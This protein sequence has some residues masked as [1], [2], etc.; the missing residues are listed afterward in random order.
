MAA[1]EQESQHKGVR[2]LPFK[3]VDHRVYFFDN[4]GELQKDGVL[5]DVVIEVEGRRFP[6]H[7][8]VLSVRCPYFRAMFSSDMAESRQKTVVLQDMDA[9]VFEEI[10]SYF[11]SG[12][13]YVSLDK[14]KSLYQ[15]AD[16]LQLDYVK[17]AC[18][19]YMVTN[20]DSSNC[21]DLY[22]FADFFSM[23]TVAYL[24]SMDAIRNRSLHFICR[25]FSEVSHTKEFYSLSVNQL[26]R[27]ISHDKLDVKQEK[28]VWE[29]VV[30]WVQHSRED[31]LQHLPSILPHIRFNLLTSDD[32][33]AILQHPMVRENSGS[34]EVSN[35]AMMPKTSNPKRR[36]GMDAQEM[37]LLFRTIGTDTTQMLCYN[38]RSKMYIKHSYGMEYL[39]MRMEVC[40]RFKVLT[41]TVTCNNDIYTLVKESSEELGLF[42]YIHLA[43]WWEKKSSFHREKPEHSPCQHIRLRAAQSKP[44]SKPVQY[45]LEVD[46][47]L[48]Y[49]AVHVT[50]Q[51]REK[52]ILLVMKKYQYSTDQWQ[53]CSKPSA[54]KQSCNVAV[55][56]GK[57]LYLI[58]NTEMHRYDPSQDSWCKVT[59]PSTNLEPC[60]AV[61]MG[62]EIFCTDAAVR[63]ISVYDVEA[64]SWSE[65]PGWSG[66]NLK[67][68]LFVLEG[69]L[70]VCLHNEQIYVYDR[71][72]G[73]W[74]Y[75]LTLPDGP[76]GICG[77]TLPV[78]R[79]Y[80]YNPTS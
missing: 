55:S 46:G 54:D 18:K 77:S 53:D 20:V 45:L 12:T 26:T 1:A 43:N 75:L 78:A 74:K 58:T 52:R 36:I 21:V 70:H 11:Y 60:T 5:Q 10:L 28:T 15:A 59:P 34:S 17:I 57:H 30:R 51:S 3:D 22:R 31:R 14:V 80:V 7:R 67:P 72:E 62:T 73:A 25:F 24:F 8:L 29:A 35:L 32:T 13:I 48:Y 6:C 41:A 79:M 69:Q 65:L 27:I 4:I 68:T 44:S 37:F 63:K 2:P 16:L 9:D 38:P 61:A 50:S 23:D 42:Q 64:D 33:A 19:K 39:D 71:S 49:L 47:H 66:P 56:S 40:T 76:W